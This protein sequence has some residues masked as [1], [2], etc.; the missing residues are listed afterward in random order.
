MNEER[1]KHG[2]GRAHEARRM[3]TAEGHGHE[4]LGDVM[5]DVIDHVSMIARDEAK[6]ARLSV[7]RY[8]EHLREDIA[9][10]AL[11]A[12]GAAVCGGLA[13]VFGLIA[14]F[15]G[16]TYLLGSAGWAFLVFAVIFTVGAVVMAGFVARTP[17]FSR[18]DEI[19]KRFP[20]VRAK[21]VAPEH[22]LVRHDS[23]EA[24]RVVTEEARREAE[25]VVLTSSSTPIQAGDQARRIGATDGERRE[26][27]K[28]THHNGQ[29]VPTSRP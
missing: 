10:K 1:P 21:E 2:N 24:H 12:V 26:E 19:A 15:W 25:R 29:H 13:L 20:A 3:A 28:V 6:I 27:I 7:K 8:G 14:L 18:K 16:L 22:A 17:R 23:L 5:R 4:A 11:F 9:P